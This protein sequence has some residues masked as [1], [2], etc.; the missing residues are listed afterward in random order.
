MV[1]EYEFE[2]IRVKIMGSGK[3]VKEKEKE[4]N[5]GDVLNKGASIR[6]SKY[7]PSETARVPTTENLRTSP[8]RTNET[9]TNIFNT[10]ENERPSK[11]D[12]MVPIIEIEGPTPKPASSPQKS[13]PTEPVSQPRKLL[14]MIEAARSS[15]R[16][17]SEYSDRQVEI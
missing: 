14:E 5:L 7:K 1:S 10:K 6:K 9:V 12:Q 16:D 17:F 13:F 8:E 3:L 2:P 11:E 15:R 4:K